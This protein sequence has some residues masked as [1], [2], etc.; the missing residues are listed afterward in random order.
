MIGSLIDFERQFHGQNRT[1]FQPG[2]GLCQAG[3][4]KAALNSSQSNLGVCKVETFRTPTSIRL[5]HAHYTVL[6]GNSSP[7]LRSPAHPILVLGKLI[8][9]RQRRERRSNAKMSSTEANISAESTDQE[10]RTIDDV[11]VRSKIHCFMKF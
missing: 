10:D 11:M 4:E 6:C 8:S 1:E 3:R 7:F 2:R 9:Q 5:Y